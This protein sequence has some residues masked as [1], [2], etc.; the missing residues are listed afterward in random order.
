MLNSNFKVAYRVSFI[1]Y[2]FECFSVLYLGIVNRPLHPITYSIF[3]AYSVITVA[4]LVRER[5]KP[6]SEKAHKYFQ[7]IVFIVANLL[8]TVA[9]NSAQAFVYSMCFTS[10][11]IFMFLD[12]KLIRF[13]MILSVGVV[14]AAEILL[15]ASGMPN[16]TMLQYNYGA[17]V[18]LFMNWIIATMVSTI[19]FQDR[20]NR[21]QERSLDDLLK[22]V[23]VKCDEAMAATRSKTQFLAHMSH[24]IR[25]PINSVM[26]MNEMIIRES[27]EQD[28]RN[29]A[30]E[31]KIAADSL[32]GIIN[33]ILDLTKIEAGKFSIVP[34]EYSLASLLNDMYN[35][36]R[37][38]AEAKQ[39]YFKII[40]D[41]TLPGR[42]YGDD[43]RLK[44]ILMNLLTNAVKYT[45]KGAVTLE[46]YPE[47][48][49]IRFIVKDTGIGI[50]AEDIDRLFNAFDRIEENR[51][52]NIEGT[53]LGMNITASLLKMMGS[54][55]EVKSV[56]GEGS[57]FSF[58]IS[59]GV[60]DFT[61]IGKMDFTQR[62]H[63]HEEY[64]AEFEAPEANVLVVDDNKM[65]R[66]VFI[67]L[68]KK[69]KIQIDEASSGKECLELTAAKKYD[70]IFMDHMMPEMDGI[71]TLEALR[72]DPDNLCLSVPVIA[73]T[74]NAVT[75]AREL[76]LSKGFDGFLT[77]PIDSKKL[78]FMMVSHLDSRYIKE[79][80]YDENIE[81]DFAEPLELPDMEGVDWGY[82][83]LHFS[84]EGLLLDT[85]RLFSAG[86]KR[87]A[88][89]LDSYFAAI[90]EEAMQSSYRIKVHSMKS[91]AAMVGFVQ[92]AGMAME[93]ENA[94]RYG[95]TEVICA[96]HPVFI[97]RWR[98]FIQPL[99]E[100]VTNDKS[101]EGVA[102]SEEEISDIVAKIRSA[103]EDMDVDALDELSGR[104]DS[105]SFKGERAERAEN[106]KAAILGF[107]IEKLM[108]V[109]L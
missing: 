40:A 81:A 35:L 44:Q 62:A 18:L 92:L 10:V 75:G 41:E 29:Y 93:L 48:D 68:L 90:E 102:A 46:V 26:G 36:I 52:R 55:I 69:T 11:I 59:Q 54:K 98:S 101:C 80:V 19:T 97:E 53:G 16:H 9:Y 4:I 96:M 91:S 74:A 103:A 1:F 87:D 31:A 95:K 84:E 65:N 34:V 77:K 45:E 6:L 5:K 22:V 15:L 60:L 86:M 43:G 94:A 100:I 85:L 66:K 47:G 8:V 70:I 38:R 27:K 109:T 105:Y 2:V 107:E 88:E 82:A 106:I 42:L 7:N 58:V 79:R 37:F 72:A 30:A 24:E 56:Y 99:A 21:E 83:R 73:L 17:G 51:N 28:I 67:N 20:Q 78:E 71:E 12:V 14:V 33:D 13:H 63:R 57:E 50:Q 61:P 104:L 25:T 3:S 39:I 64:A 32:L 23:E 49:G 76:Y 108:E 89:E